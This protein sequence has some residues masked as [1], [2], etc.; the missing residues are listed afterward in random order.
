MSYRP[1]IRPQKGA[2]L[3]RTNATLAV[4]TAL[5]SVQRLSKDYVVFVKR[6]FNK[7]VYMD[8]DGQ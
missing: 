4:S 8:G 1:N 7:T 3:T 6:K 2:N 5:I